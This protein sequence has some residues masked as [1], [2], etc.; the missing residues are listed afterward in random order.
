[1]YKIKLQLN[2]DIIKVR[3]NNF[4]DVIIKNKIL[5]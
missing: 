2:I 1:M 5:C 3:V 4:K